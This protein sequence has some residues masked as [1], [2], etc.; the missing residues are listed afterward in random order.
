M[1]QTFSFHFI[2]LF[3]NLKGICLS[4]GGTEQANKR[5]MKELN[6]RI[7]CKIFIG[8]DTLAP[9]FTAFKDGL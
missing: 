7:K 5:L 6:E 8:N 4:G 3:I 9:V 2:F 1:K